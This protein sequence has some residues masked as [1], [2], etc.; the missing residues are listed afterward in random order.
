MSVLNLLTISNVSFRQINKHTH[1]ILHILNK[2]LRHREIS[3]KSAKISRRLHR[4]TLGNRQKWHL[5]LFQYFHSLTMRHVYNAYEICLKIF[6]LLMIVLY[7][8]Q[9]NTTTHDTHTFR[10]NWT[11]RSGS[12]VEQAENDTQNRTT[13]EYYH[14]K[15]FGATYLWIKR[16]HNRENTIF[17]I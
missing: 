8:R 13:D 16:T 1:S 7:L 6:T 2:S 9:K 11:S 10:C 17:S 4:P 5:L 12:S 15:Y 3:I 14:E